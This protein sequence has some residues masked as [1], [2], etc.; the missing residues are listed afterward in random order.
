[1]KIGDTPID[2]YR[3]APSE[4]QMLKFQPGDTFMNFEPTFPGDHALFYGLF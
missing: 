4:Q 2:K 3:V 1:M